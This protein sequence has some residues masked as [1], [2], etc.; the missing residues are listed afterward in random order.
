MAADQFRCQLGDDL[1]N[2]GAAAFARDLRVHEHEQQYVAEFLAQILLVVLPH[3][4]RD[5]VSF[6]EQLRD[7]RL[8]SL[9]AIPG[10]TVRGAEVGDDVAELLEVIGDW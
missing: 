7:Q 6:L 1:L 5:F 3:R 8:V 4:V 10:A 9:L 2:P